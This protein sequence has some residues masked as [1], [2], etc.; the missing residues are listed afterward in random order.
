MDQQLRW[1]GQL[2][3]I[4][5][6]RA[7]SD[8]V[9]HVVHLGGGYFLLR[10]SSPFKLTAESSLQ[11]GDQNALLAQVR[12]PLLHETRVTCPSGSGFRLLH[13][14]TETALYPLHEPVHG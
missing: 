6:F 7:G 9:P 8:L 11:E 4:L 14:A 3:P 12:G 13:P 2:R 1:Q 10:W 5:H